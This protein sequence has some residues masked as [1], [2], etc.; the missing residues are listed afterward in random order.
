MVPVRVDGTLSEKLTPLQLESILSVPNCAL[1]FSEGTSAVLKVQNKGEEAVCLKKG[2]AM[3]QIAP[4]TEATLSELLQTESD[5]VQVG[6]A[7]ESA[8]C[9]EN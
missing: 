7:G 6:A 5:Q 9:G 2:Q 8:D 4:V 3:G 1:D